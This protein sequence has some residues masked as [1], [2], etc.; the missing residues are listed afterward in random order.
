IGPEGP[1]GNLH[2]GILGGI[3]T[4]KPLT[5]RLFVRPT[6]SIS[7][8]QKT[9]DLDM[10]PTEIETHGRHDPCVAPRLA[11]VAEAMCLLVLADLYL[12]KSRKP[13]DW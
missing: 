1:A 10:N 13:G 4:G 3:S 2:G 5:A 6:P 9:V 11:P 7:I 12:E 8:S